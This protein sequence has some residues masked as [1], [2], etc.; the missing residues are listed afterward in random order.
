MNAV[1]LMAVNKEAARAY[2]GAAIESAKPAAGPIRWVENFSASE[3]LRSIQSVERPP[4]AARAGP[5]TIIEPDGISPSVV[6]C[7]LCLHTRLERASV[8][9]AS[10][11]ADRSMMPNEQAAGGE[12]TIGDY[13][14]LLAPSEMVARLTA[15]HHSV[16]AYDEHG[17]TCLHWA[18]LLGQVE[19][20][21]A[22]LDS[23]SE[24]L[25]LQ[26]DLWPCHGVSGRQEPLQS[27]SHDF[28][29]V[30]VG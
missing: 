15:L 20:L 24:A 7:A 13:V 21:A 19:H 30:S 29:V 14:R 5:P 16:D 12:P 27:S 9:S 3:Y 22:L 25:C 23:E 11:L 2:W 1:A 8:C 18:A 28:H 10:A 6:S 17:W 4:R 26:S